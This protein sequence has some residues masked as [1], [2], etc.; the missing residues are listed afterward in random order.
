M[1]RVTERAPQS[2]QRKKMYLMAKEIGLTR[3]ERIELARYLLRRDVSS[4]SD[5]DE[6]QVLRMLDA[7]EGY[8]LISTLN[9]LRP[10]T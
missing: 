5:L 8:H 6:D 9:A 3:E 7:M 4:C 10:P 1:Q 2:P